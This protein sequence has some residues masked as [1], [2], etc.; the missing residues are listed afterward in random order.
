MVDI[1]QI[2]ILVFI[3]IATIFSLRKGSSAN[4][5]H[6]NSLSAMVKD[7]ISLLSLIA[8]L[9]TFISYTYWFTWFIPYRVN[10]SF[11]LYRLIVD[12][13]SDL[14]PIVLLCLYFFIKHNN[15]NAYR[16]VILAMVSFFLID[17]QWY[18]K[19]IIRWPSEILWFFEAPSLYGI[20]QVF[21]TL[22]II[23]LLITTI[24]AFF[25]K[26]K[27]RIFTILLFINFASQVLW[28]IRFLVESFTFYVENQRYLELFTIPCGYIGAALFFI[29]LWLVAKN[30][31]LPKY[32]NKKISKKPTTITP[33]MQL[34]ALK[35]KFELGIM[36]EEEYKTQRMEILAKL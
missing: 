34:T 31:E 35:E 12:L 21:N 14:A 11:D 13:L 16:L 17:F 25:G 33:E 1:L 28:L 19:K 2:P 3:T 7:R 9:F 22:S 5:I 18:L 24:L 23:A 15:T 26:T 4:S 8:L 30:N 6:K 10:F 20:C 29:V 36:T 32:F 27:T